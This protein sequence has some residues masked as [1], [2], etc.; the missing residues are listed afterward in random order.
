MSIPLLSEH[1]TLIKGFWKIWG[2]GL[3]EAARSQGSQVDEAVQARA[4]SQKPP[5]WLKLPWALKGGLGLLQRGLLILR[6]TTW[7]FL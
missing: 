3:V 5:G 6:R 7:L 2:W 4:G 1:H